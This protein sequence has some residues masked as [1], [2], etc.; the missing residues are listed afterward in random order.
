M[1]YN[2][3]VTSKWLFSLKDS[4]LLGQVNYVFCKTHHSTKGLYLIAVSKV[5]AALLTKAL[6]VHRK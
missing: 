5:S 2:E 6:N 1:E 3:I 4:T